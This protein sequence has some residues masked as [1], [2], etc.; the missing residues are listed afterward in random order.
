ML[1]HI[2]QCH[3]NIKQSFCVK[4]HGQQ[5]VKDKLIIRDTFIKVSMNLSYNG[6]HQYP[7]FVENILV[8][9]ESLESIL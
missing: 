6:I 3:W 4:R 9:Q 1:S 5:V 7:Y 8:T 2:Q